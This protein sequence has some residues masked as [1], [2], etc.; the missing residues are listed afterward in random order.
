MLTVVKKKDE[1]VKKKRMYVELLESN[2]LQI[3]LGEA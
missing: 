3:G 1:Q 2:V